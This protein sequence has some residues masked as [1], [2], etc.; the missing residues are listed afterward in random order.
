MY[1]EVRDKIRQ[2]PDDVSNILATNQGTLGLDIQQ[3]CADNPDLLQQIVE[4]IQGGSQDGEEEI[5]ESELQ[6]MLVG[7]NRKSLLT[8]AELSGFIGQIQRAA[9]ARLQL[10]PDDNK[11]IDYVG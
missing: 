4:E 7:S 6:N 8:K 11:N 10:T 5:S 2:N 1:K 9:N 3:L